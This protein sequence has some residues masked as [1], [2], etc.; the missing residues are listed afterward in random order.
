[1]ADHEVVFKKCHELGLNVFVKNP[2]IHINENGAR[3]GYRRAY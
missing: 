3:S 2:D 1:M